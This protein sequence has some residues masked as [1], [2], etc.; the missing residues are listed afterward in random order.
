[1][2]RVFLDYLP[3]ALRA[4]DQVADAC[5]VVGDAYIGI[6]TDVRY[7]YGIEFGVD[8]A[9]RVRRRAGPALMLTSALEAIP[10]RLGPALARA[11]PA[12]PRAM[13]GAMRE[14]ALVT[15]G[16]ARERTPVRTGRLRDSIQA[17]FG[18]V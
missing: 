10:D 5:E 15:L 2:I 17:V 4:L 18:G 13:E 14:Q 7:A 6:G 8:R 12:G 1:M 9:G 3:Q 11:L 16:L